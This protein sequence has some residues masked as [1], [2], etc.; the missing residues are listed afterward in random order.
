[1]IEADDGI[2]LWVEVTGDGPGVPLVLCHGGPGMW[3]NL[4]TL[5]ALLDHDRPVIRWDQRGCGRSEGIEGPFTLE[6]F[7]AD[8]RAIRSA[9]GIT[10]WIV[11][12]HSWGATLAL[13][14]SLADGP[15]TTGLV[16]IAGTGLGRDWHA[17]YKAAPAQRLTP[18]QLTRVEVLEEL[19]ERR[20]RPDEIEWRTLR[21]IPD[22][23]DRERAAEL[24]AIDANAP[25]PINRACN[26]A[27][28]TETKAWDAAALLGKCSA[29][30][31]PTVLIHGAED[32][33]PPSAVTDLAETIPGAELHV[34]D[35]VGHSPWLERPGAVAG[36]LRPWLS[37]RD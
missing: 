26:A 20:T 31:V 28:N 2:K 12:G 18:D 22:F 11:G 19:G 14:S 5:A 33:R 21:W 13:R 8:L 15:S 10:R 25:W 34:I 37:S 24:A 4:G 30:E 16:Y 1:M 6:R 32:P 7:L 35:G 23:A 27:L 9:L 17:A 3:D 36:I 29:M